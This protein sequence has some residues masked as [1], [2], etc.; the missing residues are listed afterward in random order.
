MDSTQ[1]KGLVSQ[2][3]V[4]KS[5]DYPSYRTLVEGLLAEGKSTGPKQSEDLTH[6]SK[7]NVQ[8]MKRWDKTAKI[9]P[10]LEAEIASVETPW[11]WLVLTEGWCGDAAQNIPVL[12]KLAEL[13]PNIELRLLLRDENLNLMDGHLTNGGRAIPKLIAVKAD[14]LTELGTWGPRP[15]EAQQLV[16]DFKAKGIPYAE[17]SE[18]IHKWYAQDKAQSIQKEFLALIQAW[19]KK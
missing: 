1:V 4:N 15:A 11:L 3:Y 14:T 19:K 16:L 8:R 7:I 2:E 13:N 12:V 10:E 18:K 9:L 17:F 6:Y 5:I